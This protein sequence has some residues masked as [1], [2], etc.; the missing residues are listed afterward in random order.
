MDRPP[1]AQQRLQRLSCYR[2]IQRACRRAAVDPWH[3]N[4]VGDAL[5][6]IA[7]KLHR[8]L[9]AATAG[10]PRSLEA[11]DVTP[12]GRSLIL[13]DALGPSFH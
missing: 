9:I 11:E 10:H 7:K 1:D 6:E 2:T 13:K 5:V 12:L 3:S 4:Q 8:Q